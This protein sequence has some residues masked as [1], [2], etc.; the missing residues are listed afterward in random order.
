MTDDRK[1]V[2]TMAE[3][4]TLDE[5]DILS[6]YEAGRKGNRTEI[7]LEFNRSYWHGWRNGMMDSYRMKGDVDSEKLAREFLAQ[8]R[9][10]RTKGRK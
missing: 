8:Q 2:A 7:G 9:T 10:L 4:E 5:R 3:L 6:G 1:P